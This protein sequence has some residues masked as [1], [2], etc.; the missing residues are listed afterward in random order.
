MTSHVSRI[1]TAV[2][3]CGCAAGAGFLQR[4]NRVAND[5]G[6]AAPS[7]AAE[8]IV[9][10]L[11]GFRSIVA[12][13]VWFRADRLQDEGRYAELA[14][15]ST[16]LTFLE[17]HTP[18]VWAYA[19]WNLAYNVSV[20]MPTP[21]DRWRW[22]EAGIR[23]LR[24]DGLRLN[25]RDAVLYKEIAWMFLLKIGAH[26][27]DA[28]AYYRSA[29][30]DIVRKAQREGRLS[31]IGLDP[32]RMAFVEADYGRQNWT[33]PFA[34]ALYWASTGLTLVRTP[35]QRN[36]LRQITYQALMLQAREDAAVAPRALQELLTAYNENPSGQ[37][38]QV[39]ENFAARHQLDEA[40]MVRQGRL[41]LPT[42]SLGN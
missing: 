33:S 21:E 28:G 11:G 31:D 38:L 5:A 1:V 41:E 36:E 13:V 18:E 17:P 19:A 23:L 27:D 29:W 2:L 12:E 35:R 16:W 8:M 6:V 24:D 7:P 4:D 15:L 10:G 37:L 39:I 22:V 25:P 14:Q 34:S 3:L 20:M 9:A 30:K 42:P 32:S 26:L 40:E